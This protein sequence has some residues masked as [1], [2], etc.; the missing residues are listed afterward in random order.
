MKCSASLYFITLYNNM[1]IAVTYI[2]IYILKA[3]QRHLLNRLFPYLKHNFIWP[4]AQDGKH[5]LSIMHE[6]GTI[7]YDFMSWSKIVNFQC[8]TFQFD[9]TV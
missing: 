6:I 2:T 3:L 7:T 9:I 8:R 4:S 5:I 1:G